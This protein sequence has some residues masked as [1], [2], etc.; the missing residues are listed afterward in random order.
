[1]NHARIAEQPLDL[2][3]Q[4]QVAEAPGDDAMLQCLKNVALL[5]QQ[6]H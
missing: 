4:V 5:K 6:R 1:V 2:G 3:L